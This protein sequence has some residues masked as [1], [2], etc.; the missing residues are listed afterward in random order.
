MPSTNL[1]VTTSDEALIAR[2]GQALAGTAIS[3]PGTIT[4]PPTPT[5]TPTPAPTPQPILG[6]PPGITGNMPVDIGTG[7]DLIEMNLAGLGSNV[8]LTVAI[9]VDGHVTAAPLSVTSPGGENPVDGQVFTIRGTWGP[10]PHTVSIAPAGHGDLGLFINSVAYNFV[11]LGNNGPSLDNRPGGNPN[12]NALRVWCNIPAVVAFAPLVPVA[13]LPPVPLPPPPPP[14]IPTVAPSV[15]TATITGGGSSRPVT[16]TLA[17]IVASLKVDDILMLPEGTHYGTAFPIVPCI[18]D[19]AGMGKTIISGADGGIEPAHDKAIFTLG[20]SGVILKNMTIQGAVIPAALGGNAAGARV[21]GAGI[22]MTLV[23]VEITRS[24]LG[25][26]IQGEATLT[27][28]N[29]HDV[30]GGNPGSGATH[31]IYA[32]DGTTTITATDCTFGVGPLGTH[33]FKMRGQVTVATNC[34]FIANDTD[35]THGGNAGSAI[36]IPDSGSFTM[37][38][39]KIIMSAAA[40]NRTLIGFGSDSGK[41]SPFGTTVT[42]NN[43]IIEAAGGTFLAFPGNIPNA[44]LVLNNVT[45][46]SG[47]FATIVGWATVT[48]AITA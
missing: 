40:S 37:N 23:N 48:G 30:G 33:A 5:P 24:Q 42:L 46:S 16:G 15:L 3:N 6:M 13:D 8:P 38:G 28:C 18:I 19:A 44:T 32:F 11:A 10:L 2:I 26:G 47:Q 4:A 21:D 31:G 9:L 43:V 20:A 27:G 17:Q 14:P 41:Q 36:D 35:P 45:Q 7:P 12:I 1:T 25:L 39:G 29:I 34:T 22:D